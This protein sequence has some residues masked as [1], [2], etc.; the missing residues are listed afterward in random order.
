M[1]SF[2]FVNPGCTR[3]HSKASLARIGLT[4][5]TLCRTIMYMVRQTKHD[6]TSWV[7]SEEDSL[8]RLVRWLN[9]RKGDPGYS[10]HEDRER[11]KVREVISLLQR[12][13]S[14]EPQWRQREPFPAPFGVER[15][16][17]RELQSKL[18]HLL[19]TQKG[20]RQIVDLRQE[21]LC[22]R[23]LPVPPR[24]L[25]QFIYTNIAMDLADSKL[26]HRLRVCGCGRYFVARSS[27]TRFCSPNCRIKFWESS[28][29]R[30]QKKREK[31]REYYMLHKAGIVK[32]SRRRNKSK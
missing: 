27:L 21:N 25:W 5:Q 26:L 20:I 32:G 23:W 28:E 15:S 8:I 31:A 10:H 17:V 14:L 30:K 16:D 9:E 1:E 4:I 7:S 22:S 24:H 18:N 2:G 12:L 11:S 13:Y 3:R 29:E 19:A 6:R